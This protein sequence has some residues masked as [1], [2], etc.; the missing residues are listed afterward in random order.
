MSEEPHAYWN[1]ESLL[2]GKETDP[3]SGGGLR[4]LRTFSPFLS[5]WGT[6]RP[7]C[8]QH[9]GVNHM[10]KAPPDSSQLCNQ[11]AA[12]C[13]M[14]LPWSLACGKREPCPAQSPKPKHASHACSARNPSETSGLP[15]TEQSLPVL[16]L[17][18]S[19]HL[20]DQHV[21]PLGLSQQDQNPG[22]LRQ[23]TTEMYCPTLLEAGSPG[24]RCQQR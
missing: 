11:R 10:V 12:S 17:G 20:I 7:G 4:P 15:D 16:G 6:L 14:Q 2:R 22:G 8:T 13:P 9:G 3:D 24:S 1:W 18:L 21:I 5:W 19:I 23:Q